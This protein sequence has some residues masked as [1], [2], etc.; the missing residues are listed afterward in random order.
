[1]TRAVRRLCTLLAVAEAVALAA[2]AAEAPAEKFDPSVDRTDPNFVT[3]SLLVFGPGEELFSCAGHACIRLECPTYKLDY[4]FSYESER[5]SD[6]LMTFFAGKLKMGLFAIPTEE[7]LK[8]YATSGRGVVQY[9]LNLPAGIKQRLWKILD[10]R[11]AEGADLP[12]DYIK[13]GCAWSVL[14]CL[15]DGLNPAQIEPGPWPE[16]YRGHQRAI[17]ASSLDHAPWARFFIHAIVGADVDRD[18]P[19]IRK[20]VV[21]A[22]FLAFMRNAKV[23]GQPVLTDEGKELLPMTLDCSAPFFTPMML[24]CL[25]VLVSIGNFF[26]RRP[27][28]DGLFLAIQTMAGSF[29]T[30]LVC[31][32]SLPATGWNWLIVPFNPLPLVFWRWRRYWAWPF[33]VVLVAWE[34]FML[35]SPH[36]LTDPAYLVLTLSY[37]VFYAK[38]GLLKRHR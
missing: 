17:I 26:V 25:L 13:R 1:M 37:I 12:Y 34:A 10:E 30:Y 5:V 19:N 38:I 22:D 35:L 27:S 23:D 7:F 9:R 36:Q 4:C 29:F 3:A 2:F 6:R 18:I 16:K 15:M 8:E 32:S 24:A 31:F 20:V 21:P 11:A 33:V 14:K 28:V